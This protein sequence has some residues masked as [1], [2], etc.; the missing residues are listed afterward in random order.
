M[1]TVIFHDG[2][3]SGD[4][5]GWTGVN[6]AVAVHADYKHTGA[7]GAVIEDKGAGGGNVV[8]VLTGGVLEWW[9]RY[10]LQIEAYS[11]DA[12]G[13]LHNILSAKN[14]ANNQF[15]LKMTFFSNND[16]L[17]YLGADHYDTGGEKGYV[18]TAQADAIGGFAG[19][20]VFH[21]LEVHG[22]IHASTGGAEIWWDNV[23]IDDLCLMNLNTTHLADI[24]RLIISAGVPDAG[25]FS[26]FV[27][28]AVVD[29]ARQV[30]GKL[31]RRR[32]VG[33][34]AIRLEV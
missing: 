22:K 11:N 31:L 18:E 24:E 21:C 20:G 8:R 29:N 25:T 14:G 15:L 16:G 2:F 6:G 17:L 32:S 23:R 12:D 33:S 7:Y 5:S 28:D 10:Y 3:E 1:M 19:D 27:D 30:G 9:L 34:R 13:V 26:I 4:T